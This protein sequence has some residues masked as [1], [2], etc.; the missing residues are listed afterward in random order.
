[1]LR[2]SLMHIKGRFNLVVS[3]AGFCL[4]VGLWP[5][6]GQQAPPTENKGVK[7]DSL[8][9]ID[10]GPEIDGMQGRQ[11][12]LRRVTIEPGGV[13]R[14][15]SHKDRPTVVHLLQGTLIIHPEG[16]ASIE[17]QEGESWSEGKETTE[18]AE[19]KGTKPVVLIVADIFKQ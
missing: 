9:T 4:M 6:I 7:S 12:R 17:H 14:L 19:N 2:R 1:M 11:L 13:V 8:T 16:S 3:L 10:L 18:W 5:A 15:H